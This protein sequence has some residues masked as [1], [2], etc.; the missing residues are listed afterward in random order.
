MAG[1]HGGAL[2]LRPHHAPRAK[3]G[4][5]C[6]NSYLSHMLFCCTGL[7]Y[8]YFTCLPLSLCSLWPTFCLI[9]R[10][11]LRLMGV[12]SVSEPSGKLLDVLDALRLAACSAWSSTAASSSSSSSSNSSS[13]GGGGGNDEPWRGRGSGSSRRRRRSRCR[14]VLAVLAA[15]RDGWRGARAEAACRGGRFCCVPPHASGCVYMRF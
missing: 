9:C 14:A 13:N 4:E 5:T 15:A 6:H 1:F 2:S 11:C 12:P 10:L 7:F 8:T 3:Q